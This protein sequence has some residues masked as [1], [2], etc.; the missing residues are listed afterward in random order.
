M[1]NSD[2]LVNSSIVEIVM[3]VSRRN[4]IKNASLVTAGALL[5]TSIVANQQ[6][7]A[8]VPAQGVQQQTLQQLT[9]ELEQFLLKF[10]DGYIE[11]DAQAVTD[12]AFMQNIAGRMRIAAINE[13]LLN[14]LSGINSIAYDGAVM[15]TPVSEHYGAFDVP[16]FHQVLAAENALFA[17]LTLAPSRSA[18]DKLIDLL[19]LIVVKFLGALGITGALDLIQSIVTGLIDLANGHMTDFITKLLQQKFKEAWEIFKNRILPVLRDKDFWELAF[20]KLG[21]RGATLKKLK[22]LGITITEKIAPGVGWVITIGTLMIEFWNNRD[23]FA[24]ILA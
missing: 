15:S 17:T 21:F 4:L 2:G 19:K 3:E 23:K 22:D 16:H 6:S 12:F 8:L 7:G 9:T 18:S 11:T 1:N 14:P 24:Q 20:E 13:G 5:P 10:T